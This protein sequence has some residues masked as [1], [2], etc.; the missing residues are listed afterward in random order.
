MPFIRFSLISLF[1]ALFGMLDAGNSYSKCPVDKNKIYV[2]FRIDDYGI[3][4]TRFYD[5]LTGVIKRTNS[6][7]TIAVVPYRK[8]Q[9]RYSPISD[10]LINRLNEY[11]KNDAGIEIALHGYTHQNLL[12]NGG[13]S[14]FY[15]RPYALQQKMIHQ[16]K[17]F[18]NARLTTPVTTFIPPWNTYDNITTDA[19]EAEGFNCISAASYGKISTAGLNPH[20]KYAPYTIQL[21]SLMHAY[22]SNLAE[23]SSGISVVLFHAYDFKEGQP[24]SATD[25]S[26]DYLANNRKIDLPEFEQFINKLKKNP[27][28]VFCTFKELCSNQQNDLSASRYKSSFILMSIQPFWPR[29]SN[30]S[31]LYLNSGSFNFRNAYNL[32]WP[33]FFYGI[34]LFCGYLLSLKAILR[35][36]RTDGSMMLIAG[37]MI[38]FFSVL[39]LLFFRDSLRF[40]V[41]FSFWVG[42][43]LGYIRSVYLSF[44]AIAV[45]KKVNK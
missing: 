19:L 17:S 24:L 45:Q 38:L 31:F 40:L 42:I 9:N 12:G 29:I 16:G 22:S 36:I 2:V 4:N 26:L 5:Q 35:R 20:L 18:L 13:S 44:I 32:A 1:V 34:I 39:S 33:F 7:L 30:E 10:S 25:H 8:W 3:D 14:E 15:G 41:L 23:N 37:L 11:I 43:V 28:V 21:S 27:R 6:K